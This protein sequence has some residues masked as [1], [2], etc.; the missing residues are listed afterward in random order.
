[1]PPSYHPGPG[2]I[3]G[4]STLSDAVDVSHSTRVSTRAT[5]SGDVM[6]TNGYTLVT[7]RDDMSA[8]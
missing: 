1:M 7:L 3:A 4:P 2:H 6:S 5:V 8:G